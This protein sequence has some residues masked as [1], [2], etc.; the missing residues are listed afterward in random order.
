MKKD[1]RDFRGE[2][3]RVSRPDFSTTTLY[4]IQ[5]CHSTTYE[6]SVSTPFSKSC[7]TGRRVAAAGFQVEMGQVGLRLFTT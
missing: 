7:H 5:P 1:L 3:N 4:N 2:L 6:V